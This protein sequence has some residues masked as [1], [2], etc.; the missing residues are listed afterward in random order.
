MHIVTL[1][2]AAAHGEAHRVEPADSLDDVGARGCG[3]GVLSN[4]GSLSG[5][6]LVPS[7]GPSGLRCLQR[8]RK[9]LA[10]ILAPL[11]GILKHD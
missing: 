3:H 11:R 8:P 9:G 6:Y 4:G 1:R 7:E 2:D 10:A 5:A